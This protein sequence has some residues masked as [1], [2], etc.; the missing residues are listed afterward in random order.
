MVEDQVD[1]ML[2]QNLIRPSV[3]NY[4]SN[5]VL[6]K[7]KD[8]SWRFCVDYRKVNDI[9]RKD[10]YPLPRIDECLDTLGGSKWF[11]TIDL[12]SG[13]FQVEIAES[14]AH[15]TAFVTRKDLYEF[16]VMP[17]GMCNSSATFQ[18][19][20]N[21]VMAGLTYETCLVYIDDIVVFSDT[22]ETHLSRLEVVLH[23]LESAGLKI[24]PDK[25][26]MLQREVVF[27]G[28]V[29]S[30]EGIKAST[31]KTE[32]ITSWPTPKNVKEVRS[33]LGL[34]RYYR[35]H[36]KDFAKTAAPLHAL[37]GKYARFHWD[38][39][40]Q[41]AFEEMKEKLTT[42]PIMS[43]PRDEG[44]FI[45]DC[46]ASQLAIGAVLSQVQDGEE[47]VVAYA[48]RLYSKAELNYCVTSQELL[49]VV[50]FCKYF[51][52]YLL[53]RSFIVRTDHS[54]LT[55]LRRTPKPVGQQSRWLEQLEEY[56]F[57][58]QHRSGR[59]HNNVDAMSRRPCRQ[60]HKI[61]SDDVD[62]TGICSQINMVVDASSYPDGV[63]G[64]SKTRLAELQAQDPQLGEYYGLKQKYLDTKPEVKNITGCSE[65][66]KILWSQ[67]NDIVSCDGCYTANI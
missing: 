30:E 39:Q 37:T 57:V 47:K 19:L 66:T 17:Q 52:Q 64:W 53:G 36:I 14:D 15:K 18:R 63:D 4:A 54:A 7:K 21:L 27:L 61:D 1:Q 59:K 28:H 31:A 9:T 43:F 42:A 45:L 60:C 6:V 12:R 55:W 13:F 20:M 3:S 22:L 2:E 38:E 62:E 35:K 10:A 49:A 8:S 51:R 29:I 44:Q 58:V 48:S 24:R 40:C 32:A 67:W 5:V 33:F 56:L 46:D 65:Y 34:C 41:R 23:R 26:K 50:Y 11:S 25:C 16:Q